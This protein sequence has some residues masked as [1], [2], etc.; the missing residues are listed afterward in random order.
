MPQAITW[1]T[2]L[3]QCAD[4]ERRAASANDLCAQEVES[5][6]GEPRLLDMR[7]REYIRPAPVFLTQIET[8]EEGT[9]K[10]WLAISS[11]SS[12]AKMTMTP[13]PKLS[14]ARHSSWHSG[15]VLSDQP[16][17]RLWASSRTLDLPDRS[18][19]GE[20]GRRYRIGGCCLFHALENC[21]QSDS[22]ASTFPLHS[23]T[24]L[25]EGHPPWR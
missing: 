12:S 15:S 6:F 1:T 22:K 13:P 16:R 10:Q 20:G 23:A 18:G 14:F 8:G 9:R 4:V 11:F 25:C 24:H 5:T 3:V 19:R 17:M 21:S 2:N 7:D